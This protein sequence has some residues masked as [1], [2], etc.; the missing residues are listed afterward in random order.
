MDICFRRRLGRR[1]VLLLSSCV[2]ALGVAWVLDNRFTMLS[3]YPKLGLFVALSSFSRQPFAASPIVNGTTDTNWYAP[4]AT[5]I[6][7]LNNV[8]NASGVYGFIFNSSQTPNSKY[9]TYNWCNMPHARRQEYPKASDEYEL[10]YVEVVS[11]ASSPS[12]K[13]KE[14]RKN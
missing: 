6:N 5:Q 7:N 3:S 9:G 8:L 14:L 10:Q 1:L 4:N 12:W 13:T 2:T 11:F